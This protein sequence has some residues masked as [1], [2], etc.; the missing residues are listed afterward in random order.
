MPINIRRFESIVVVIVLLAVVFFL[1]SSE[2]STQNTSVTSK[3][4]SIPQL[5]T[6]GFVQ[7]QPSAEIN[8]ATGQGLIALTGDCYQV[9]GNTDATQ[10]QS[11]I[12]GLTG[13]IAANGRPNTQDLM[14]D[15]FQNLGIKVLMVKVVGIQNNNFIGRLILQQGDKIL[16]L[17]SRPSDGIAIAV[18]MNSTIY[19]NQTLFQQYGQKVC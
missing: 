6:N 4:N 3:Q 9:V 19:F 18:R 2:T 13:Q 16:S 15:I 5:S 7:V 8:N 11:I 1:S 14:K 17:D 12:N 10:A